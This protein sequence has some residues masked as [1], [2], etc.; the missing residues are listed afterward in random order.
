ME[1]HRHVA[2][3]TEAPAS[4][5]PAANSPSG[6]TASVFLAAAA[7]ET[8]A[9]AAAW[10][11]RSYGAT[12]EDIMRFR[13]HT[14]KLALILATGRRI[15]LAIGRVRAVSRAVRCAVGPGWSALLPRADECTRHLFLTFR[16]PLVRTIMS[17][18]SSSSGV[19]PMSRTMPSGLSRSHS[20]SGSR[21]GARGPRAAPG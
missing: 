2:A 16:R 4:S 3:L 9:A 20:S 18:V 6:C 17:T 5:S 10:S 8:A 7:A 13:A 11:L 14:W 15:Y 21:A 19:T 1:A 12:G